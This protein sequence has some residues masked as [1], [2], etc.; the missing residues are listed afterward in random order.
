MAVV[1]VEVGDGGSSGGGGGHDD[2]GSDDGGSDGGSGGGGWWDN[3]DIDISWDTDTDDDYY[4]DD[5]DDYVPVQPDYQETEW[6]LRGRWMDY[7]DMILG[8]QGEGEFT[9]PAYPDYCLWWEEEP[10]TYWG[11]QSSG[12]PGSSGSSS[13]KKAGG[14]GQGYWKIQNSWGPDW[15]HQGFAYFAFTDDE[16]YGNCGILD[17]GMFAVGSKSNPL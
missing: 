2:G 4:Y 15:G 9:A 6:I 17:E 13:G 16:S 8:C 12:A 5:S 7:W 1:G 11:V 10:V 3:W 14:T